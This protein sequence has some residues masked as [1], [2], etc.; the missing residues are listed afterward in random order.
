M[1]TDET[2]KWSGG[3]CLLKDHWFLKHR[4]EQINGLKRGRIDRKITYPN[5]A[6]LVERPTVD[7]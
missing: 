4:F 7:G 6:Q 1:K 5:I 3:L 2:D